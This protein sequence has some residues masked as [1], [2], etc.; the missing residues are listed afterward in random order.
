MEYSLPEHRLALEALTA[1]SSAAT[2]E[3][4]EYVDIDADGGRWGLTLIVC[5]RK[6]KKNYH[7]MC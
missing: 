1:N 5:L 3:K 6:L 2:E 4:I 7:Q